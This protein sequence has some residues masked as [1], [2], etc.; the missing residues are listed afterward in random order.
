[1]YVTAANLQ[2]SKDQTSLAV[3]ALLRNIESDKNSL[4]SLYRAKP[5][6]A[7]AAAASQ[8]PD[9]KAVSERDRKVAASRRLLGLPPA[10]PR[11]KELSAVEPIRP[12]PRTYRDALQAM[13]DASE[14]QANASAD[15][16]QQYND[17]S[18]SPAEIIK[19][20]QSAQTSLEKQ[21]FNVWGIRTPRLV[22]FEYAGSNF[23][24]PYIFLSVALLALISPL[25]A[26][27]LTTLYMTR[28][29][30][31]NAIIK[32]KSFGNIFP[33]VLNFV[34]VQFV[35]ISDRRAEGFDRYIEIGGLTIMRMIVM[36]VVITPMIVAYAYS[37]IQ[38]W[39]FSPANYF[40]VP[41]LMYIGVQSLALL[42]QEAVALRQIYFIEQNYG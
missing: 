27:W 12:K 4:N 32:T 29:R 38:F 17:P 11:E 16:L 14:K 40:V 21:P 35:R 39:T 41:I 7:E 24:L 36:L 23:Q 15:V 8:T 9:T 31:M 25:I 30:E 18:K 2:Y 37:V 13:V 6:S 1:M 10:K 28:Q 3:D 22:E 34:P 33:H 20:L 5:Q 26:G 42:A 19:Q